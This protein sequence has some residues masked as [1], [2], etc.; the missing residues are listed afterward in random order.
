MSEVNFKRA[1]EGVAQ[2]RIQ[3]DK[4]HD[5]EQ[6]CARHDESRKLQVEDAA[7]DACHG[8]RYGQVERRAVRCIDH[9]YRFS[10]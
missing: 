7:V 3:E 8:A 2:Y 10:R 5:R 1:V 6:R 4:Q 9:D